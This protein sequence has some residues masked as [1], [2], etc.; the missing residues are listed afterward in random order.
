MN[1]AP[2]WI[3]PAANQIQ[4]GRDAVPTLPKAA[5]G[6]QRETGDRRI[7]W[8]YFSRVPGLGHREPGTGIQVQVQVRAILCNLSSIQSSSHFGWQPRVAGGGPIPFSPQRSPQLSPPSCL[9]LSLPI[10][11]PLTA[12]R[13]HLPHLLSSCPLFHPPSIFRPCPPFSL[14]SKSVP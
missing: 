11:Q 7:G 3:R 12:I 8:G 1:R 13:Y 9:S 4:L 10:R 5:D 6:T 14:R 2:T